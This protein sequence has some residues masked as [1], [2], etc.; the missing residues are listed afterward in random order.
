M[1]RADLLAAG[2]V[3]NGAGQL[4]NP[5]V[6]PRR[7]LQLVHGRAHQGAS[8]FIQRAVPAHFGRLHFG[9]AHRA[10]NRP[11]FHLAALS[12]EPAALDL[13]GGLHPRLD[14]GGILRSAV[15]AQLLV[16]D[17]RHLDVDVDAVE[18]RAGDAGPKERDS[19]Y[20][21]TVE[22]EQVQA[23]SGSP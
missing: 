15:F 2:Q 13:P 14:G 6:G 12:S 21:V 5:V 10:E 4:E 16:L 17:A 1:T 19:W 8:G 7:Q 11:C 23:R 3:G 18:Q 22:E 20:L 9:V